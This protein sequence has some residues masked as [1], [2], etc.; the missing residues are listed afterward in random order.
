VQAPQVAQPHHDSALVTPATRHPQLLRIVARLRDHSLRDLR[1]RQFGMNLHQRLQLRQML[2][3]RR[4]RHR[5]GRLQILVRLLLLLVRARLR[6][7]LPVALR[8]GRSW[9][10]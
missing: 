4:P 8:R 7:A 3:L 9:R 5:R 1:T 10:Q 2:R 6:L